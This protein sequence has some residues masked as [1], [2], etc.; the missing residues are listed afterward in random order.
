MDRTLNRLSQQIAQLRREYVSHPFDVESVDA[1]PIVQFRSWFDE[2]VRAEQP[3]PE[4]MT[5]STAS[6]GGQVSARIVLLRQIDDRG[7]V[8]FTNYES[9]KSRQLSANPYVALTFYWSSLNRQ[10]NITGDAEKL[11]VQESEDYFQTRPRGSQIAAWTSPQSR[12]IAS[13]D[14]LE[15]MFAEVEERFSQQSVP[16]PPFWG[17]F[18][19]K[20]VKIEFWQGRENRLHD[21][22][23]YKLQNGA[24]R[25]SRL[26]P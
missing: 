21:R 14:V 12:E 8:F 23:E 26:A 15:R 6:V 4:A 2:A 18:R 5:I 9:R 19:V 25:I 3:D 17:G 7:F 22:V 20:P 10:V 16:C 11:A 13:R 24:W 1:D